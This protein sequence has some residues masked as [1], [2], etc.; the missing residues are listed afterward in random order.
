MTAQCYASNNLK[1][2]YANFVNTNDQDNMAAQHY[3]F[4]RIQLTTPN[5]KWNRPSKLIYES[6]LKLELLNFNELGLSW[7]KNFLGCF[8]GSGRRMFNDQGKSVGRL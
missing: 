2:K 6:L 7:L 4:A 3:G 8:R 5:G 1:H